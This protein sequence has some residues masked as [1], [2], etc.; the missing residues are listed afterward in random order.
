[1]NLTTNR[2]E[3]LAALTTAA[4][5]TD[6]RATI[7]ILAC[8]RLSAAGAGVVVAGTDQEMG[9]RATV[10]AT[11]GKPGE[12]VTNAKRLVDL[13]KAC[14]ADEIT[15]STDDRD[16]LNVAAGKAKFRLAT[17]DP[18][19][20]PE[21]PKMPSVAGLTMDAAELRGVLDRIGYAMS[22]DET[23]PTL[24]G[25]RIETGEGTTW[26]ATDGHRLT[27]MQTATV[28]APGAVTLPRSAVQA[29][30]PTMPDDGEV[31]LRW[32][33]GVAWVTWHGVEMWCRLVEGEF[34]DYR[35]VIPKKRGATRATVDVA[36]MVASLRRVRVVAS[37]RTHGVK[38]S[39]G[40]DGVQV[41]SINPDVGEATDTAEAEV[42]GAA[43]CFGVNAD[44][45]ID[46]LTAAGE[47]AEIAISDDVS[48]IV[49]T[50]PGDDG[51]KAVAMPMRL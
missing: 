32:S 19:D 3:L 26:T 44:Y 34:P 41:M 18:H 9:V 14:D 48:P 2:T 31:C 12:A 35:Q 23:R 5:A 38:V 6:P 17:M 20:W 10:A 39:I 4:R 7:P 30:L 47:T 27:T 46:A 42:V 37:D 28:G 22:T 43:A 33:D 25:I 51:F 13:V 45:L 50:A 1:M 8:L 29:V 11:V 16:A 40:E 21:A 15:L 36:A 49:V 24:N